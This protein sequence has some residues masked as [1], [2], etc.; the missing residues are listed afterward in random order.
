[1]T[2]HAISVIAELFVTGFNY[3]NGVTVISY[4]CTS[5]KL[6][7]VT[8]LLIDLGVDF[9]SRLRSTWGRVVFTWSPSRLLVGSFVFFSSQFSL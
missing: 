1:M 2:T 4:R 5:N 9:K 3:D 8:I 6:E 7:K